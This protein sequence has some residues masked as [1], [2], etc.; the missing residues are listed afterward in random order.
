MSY[1]LE[2]RQ[3]TDTHT[4]TTPPLYSFSVAVWSFGKFGGTKGFSCLPGEKK[5]IDTL[6]GLQVN[7]NLPLV[8][9]SS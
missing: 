7:V 6:G 8:Q 2:E 5:T 4:L 1:R 3:E 9:A